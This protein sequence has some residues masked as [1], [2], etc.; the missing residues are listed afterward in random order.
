MVEADDV[1]S[2]LAPVAL[3]FDQFLGIDV[4]AIVRG[5]SAGVA[6]ASDGGDGA[7]V[8]IDLTKENPAAFVGIGFFSVLVESVVKLA[9]D[10]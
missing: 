4:I 5:V 3:N 2:A 9:R 10:F 1:F 8:I 6:G 7:R